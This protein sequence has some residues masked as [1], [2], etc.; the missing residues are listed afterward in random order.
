MDRHAH[1][2]I[3]LFNPTAELQL[4]R[5]VQEALA[6]V[7]KHPGASRVCVRLAETAEALEAMVEDNAPGFDLR[8]TRSAANGIGPH[9]G[10]APC[11][12]APSPSVALRCHVQS[13]IE[14]GSLA[15][16]LDVFPMF[17]SR[18]HQGT[19]AWHPHEKTTVRSSGR[20]AP[21]R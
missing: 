19:L 10:L 17:G 15:Y 9:F 2:C 14:G 16:P 12:S 3:R 11:G 18:V 5:I 4:L 13:L 7:R 21:T 1:H 6:N 8:H 20:A